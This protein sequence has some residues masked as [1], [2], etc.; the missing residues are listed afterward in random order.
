MIGQKFDLSYSLPTAQVVRFGT[1]H[2]RSTN[3]IAW[4]LAT[5]LSDSRLLTTRSINS[6][7]LVKVPFV[8]PI[9]LFPCPYLLNQFRCLLLSDR[10]CRHLTPLMRS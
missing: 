3:A 10:P 7:K 5:I 9:A 6:D 2:E 4:M 8:V 1:D